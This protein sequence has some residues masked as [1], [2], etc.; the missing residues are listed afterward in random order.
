MMQRG[1]AV[2]ATSSRVPIAFILL[3][4]VWATAIHAC[5]GA[6]GQLPPVRSI[7]ALRAEPRLIPEG[8]LGAG[9]MQETFEY[10]LVL[11]ID[12]RDQKG[13]TTQEAWREEMF[14]GTYTMTDYF[15]R[16]SYYYPGVTGLYLLGATESSDSNNGVA[17]WY[18]IEYDKADTPGKYYDHPWNAI[19]PE[20]RMDGRN[21]GNILEAALCS[22]DVHV[23]FA[24]L[25]ADG[26]GYIS[27]DELHIIAI[28]AG[29]EQSYGRDKQ[30]AT[31][32]HRSGLFEGVTLDGVVLLEWGQGGGYMMLGEL[33]P[34]GSMI[35]YGLVCH[36][37]GHDLGLPDLYDTDTQK[38]VSRGI[39][40]WGLMASG[41]WCNLGTLGDCPVLPCAWSKIRMGWIS[42]TELGLVIGGTKIPQVA[43]S[44][45]A[46]KLLS[47]QDQ[48]YLVT[49][50]QR[51]GYD[52][53]LVRSGPADGLLIWHIDEGV[54]DTTLMT[55]KVNAD[56]THKGVDLECADAYVADH[57]MDADHLDSSENGGDATDPWYSGNNTDF[58]A[59]SVPD[60]RDYEGNSTLAFVRNV[61]QSADTMTADMGGAFQALPIGSINLASNGE[62]ASITAPGSSDTLRLCYTGW[63][64]SGFTDL[65]EYDAPSLSW[66]KVN[67]WGWNVAGHP[68]FFA[69]NE[70]RRQEVEYSGE[71]KLVAWGL[72]G[73]GCDEPADS[74]FRVDVHLV[75]DTEGT[76]SGNQDE[77][78]GWN[79]GFRDTSSDEFEEIMDAVYYYNPTMLGDPLTFFPAWM[80]V[81]W[82][83]ELHLE[84]EVAPGMYWEDMVLA[85]TVAA[86]DS[87]GQ[88]QVYCGDAEFQDT[89]VLIAGPGYYEAELGWMHVEGPTTITVTSG[90]AGFAWDWMSLMTVAPTL[91]LTEPPSMT[92]TSTGLPTT[93]WSA[94]TNALKYHVEWSTDA[95][96]FD[97]VVDDSTVTEPEYVPSLS[98]PPDSLGDGFYWWRVAAQTHPGVWSEPTTPG[99]F[100]YDSQPPVITP[101]TIWADTAYAGPYH[102][103]V[104]ARDGVSW[105]N[106][107]QLYYRYNEA[108]WDSA[109]MD[110]ADTA[111]SAWI[112]AVTDSTVIDYYTE[113]EDA[114]ANVAT[115]PV[116]AP[117]SYYRFRSP[118]S[119]VGQQPEGPAPVAFALAQNRPNPF[120]IST[121]FRYALP[122]DCHVRLEV[123][124]IRGQKMATLV[125]GYE[126]AGHKAVS[127]DA[128]SLASG[129]Y[130]YRLA[131]GDFVAT[132]KMVLLH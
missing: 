104:T 35:E 107:V 24:Q 73:L 2:N 76:T 55:N 36:E 37:M 30:P 120:G 61:S 74:G 81:G 105:V 71:F 87:S 77:L 128:H 125:D 97:R 15:K 103:A 44:P 25:D 45:V 22:A 48:Y 129:I 130:F 109:S 13:I 18:T 50:R 85:F 43:T 66:I 79:I 47:G 88:I 84:F 101:L 118:T 83:E 86:V 69:G 20:W 3:T 5:I 100:I 59:A 115:D 54:I 9:R 63:D 80:G 78:P 6:D 31:W 29:Y 99:T 17:G 113:A 34:S 114:A 23:N 62:V 33:A 70:I 98:L 40:E 91:Y 1:Y 93:Q 28:L 102:V 75:G 58:D 46:V 16:A 121:Q 49:N 95:E 82:V 53:S 92:I 51:V 68:N 7:P 19:G 65:Y 42:P 110:V 127:W 119:G 11:L 57:I 108:P 10:V 4:L 116:G 124:N 117:A 52:R 64:C 38:Y 96:F 60:T 39:G 21:A 106:S 12:F 41:D 14:G 90:D 26:N 89:Q 32:R 72:C 67:T 8:L 132:R 94:V 27:A 112:P 111:Y 131:A 56:E 126:A 123:F 122:R